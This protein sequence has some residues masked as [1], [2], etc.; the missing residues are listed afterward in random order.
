MRKMDQKG[1][2]S[3]EF[4]LIIAIMLVL[5]LLIASYAG[6]ENESNV[7]LSA[8]RSGAMN[9]TT[10]AVLLNSSVEP[11][12][13]DDIQ[14]I[15]GTGQDLIISIN[16]STVPPDT[17]YSNSILNST[18]NSIAAQGYTRIN[19]TNPETDPLNDYISTSRHTY[20]VEIA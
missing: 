2:I 4:A 5:V 16:L 9:A 8:A 13:V 12:R 20:H 19:S 15:N 3:I 6:A 11:T 14:L 18:L 1:Q 7:V 10:N 17:N